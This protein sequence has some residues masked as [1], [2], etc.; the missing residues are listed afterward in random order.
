MSR[1]GSLDMASWLGYLGLRLCKAAQLRLVAR[2]GLDFGDSTHRTSILMRW[3][4]PVCTCRA[5]TSDADVPVF[6]ATG[7]IVDASRSVELA[8][9]VYQI[10]SVGRQVKTRE[11]PFTPSRRSF[12]SIFT[13]SLF[14]NSSAGWGGWRGARMRAMPRCNK[15]KSRL[16]ALPLACVGLFSSKILHE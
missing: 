9:V 6:A 16:H 2:P 7:I 15:I 8:G 11:G 5:C 13:A 14:S 10:T 12:A 4:S 1:H 3:P